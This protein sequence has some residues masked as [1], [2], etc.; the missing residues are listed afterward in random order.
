MN[1][2]KI[3]KKENKKYKLVKIYSNFALYKDKY[4]IKQC[5]TFH[6]LGLITE[7]VKPPKIYVNPER[8]IIL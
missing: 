6:E 4:G 7:Q 2:P 3:Y 8:V 1:I 5:F